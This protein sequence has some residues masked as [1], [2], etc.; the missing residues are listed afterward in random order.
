MNLK[1][2]YDKMFILI[3]L[4]WLAVWVLAIMDKFIIAFMLSIILMLL[5]LIIGSA[6][7]EVIKKKYL[8]YPLI[9]W[10]VVWA[11]GFY[12]AYY[13]N[14]HETQ[15]LFLGFNSSFGPVVYFYWIGGV[16][17][18]TLGYYFNKNAWLNDEEWEEFVEKTK[19]I[20]QAKEG[21]LK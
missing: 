16:L 5:H 10:A 7:N 15:N 14:L 20:K 6:H 21:D 19:R 17:T 3:G 4:L 13:N 18:L 12:L 11:I 2:K 1:G 9:A 8:L